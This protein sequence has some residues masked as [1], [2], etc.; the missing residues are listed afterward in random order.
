MSLPELDPQFFPYL[1]EP[2]RLT[3]TNPEDP[4]V[5][6]YLTSSLEV[7]LGR[8]KVEKIYYRLKE[9]DFN[10][11]SFF[12]DA[13]KE[14]DIRVEFDHSKLNA[15]PKEG[16]LM[17]V[18]NHPFGV[19]D[20]VVLCDLAAKTRGDLRIM[21]HALLCQGRQLRRISCQSILGRPRKR[22]RPIFAL[23]NWLWNLFRRIY[24]S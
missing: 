24:R 13:L 2:P 10:I 5:T 3:Y 9:K 17:F 23:N 16:P 6:R 8:N 14:A 12:E 21:L 20:G 19:V 4:W 22:S 1:R 7:L 15:F 11:F 18:A